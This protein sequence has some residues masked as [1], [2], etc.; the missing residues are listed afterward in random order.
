MF[1]CLRP[2]VELLNPISKRVTTEGDFK[3]EWGLDPSD[4]ATVLAI[5]G[6]DTDDVPGVEGVGLITA[7]KYL[8][9]ELSDTAIAR[10]RI[11]EGLTLIERNRRLVT[12][13]YGKLSS[14]A[15]PVVRDEFNPEGAANVFREY[16]FESFLRDPLK[17][18][19]ERLLVF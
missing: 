1:Q 3:E 14:K 6:C 15:L 16:G 19:W 17:T 13:P 11:G 2:G 5:A 12:L 10:Q 9:G 7:A 4:W 18:A 8:R